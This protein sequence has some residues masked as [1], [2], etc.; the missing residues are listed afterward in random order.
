MYIIA[1]FLQ[2][3][4]EY[5]KKK[6][7]ISVIIQ[8]PAM[9]NN[10][11]DMTLLCLGD[12]SDDD[13]DMLD[14]PY[15][16]GTDA[17]LAELDELLA[18]IV[19]PAHERRRLSYIINDDGDNSHWDQVMLFQRE[20]D[21]NNCVAVPNYACVHSSH[22]MFSL[23]DYR[24]CIEAG[25]VDDFEHW[26]SYFNQ[27]TFRPFINYN[28]DTPGYYRDQ[29]TWI[30]DH[31]EEAYSCPHR[32]RH[33]CSNLRTRPVCCDDG[34]RSLCWMDLNITFHRTISS[35]NVGMPICINAPV[36][37]FQVF[38]L[39]QHPGYRIREMFHYGESTAGG[40]K[41]LRGIDNSACAE[42]RKGA[43]I[44]KKLMQIRD[45][46]NHAFDYLNPHEKMIFTSML[47]DANEDDDTH[48][49][50][51][52]FMYGF[53]ISTSRYSLYR[54][55]KESDVNTI[56]SL[57]KMMK[58]RADSPYHNIMKYAG[59]YDIVNTINRHAV[60]VMIMCEWADIL[61]RLMHSV[62]DMVSTHYHSL[63]DDVHR[64]RQRKQPC[65][66]LEEHRCRHQQYLMGLRSVFEVLSILDNNP[67]PTSVLRLFERIIHDHHRDIYQGNTL[68][69]VLYHITEDECPMRHDLY[70]FFETIGWDFNNF[71]G[72]SPPSSVG[73]FLLQMLKISTVEINYFRFLMDEF[74]AP[75]LFDSC[76]CGC[77]KHMLDDGLVLSYKIR[78]LITSL[79][80]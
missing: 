60:R 23:V 70:E 32:Q 30:M 67:R 36:K 26:R 9:D 54:G 42:L 49:I 39:A 80:R 76:I 73:V 51:C 20:V 58:K 68:A 53:D 41:S 63:M 57:G 52:V 13:I 75:Q 66:S 34:C 50:N 77:D 27:C 62:G 19:A 45:V 1:K 69:Q 11:L 56:S 29:A 6:N 79:M 61:Y 12:P 37:G 71:N 2:S 40:E 24:S 7:I 48:T 17:D 65:D 18:M 4:K 46:W 74:S 25:I 14:I 10:Q 22:M 35:A 16:P 21:R 47:L 43:Y 59:A 31:F 44:L 78:S 8:T 55:H 64:F 3:C 28:V 15:G 5:N 72:I 33:Q 38:S